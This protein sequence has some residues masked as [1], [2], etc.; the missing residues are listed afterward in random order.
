[1]L[2]FGATAFGMPFVLTLYAQQVLGFSAMKFGVTSVVFP[3]MAAIGS[4]LG[5]SIVLRVGFR[6]VASVGMALM[7]GGCAL[8]TQVSVDGTYFGDLSLLWFSSGPGWASP[9]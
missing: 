6:P 9:S 7:I 2:L 3:L 8:L 5:Q 1:M 4:I